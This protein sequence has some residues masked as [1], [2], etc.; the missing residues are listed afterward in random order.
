M[1]RWLGSLGNDAGVV[2]R[3]MPVVQQSDAFETGGHG[4]A[5]REAEGDEVRRGPSAESG[6]RPGQ[7]ICER[8]GVGS[9]RQQIQ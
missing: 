9:A 1:P 4:A 5:G 6:A 2:M 8:W 3:R 7:A